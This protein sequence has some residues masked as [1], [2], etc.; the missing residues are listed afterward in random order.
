MEVIEPMSNNQ[1]ALYQN[2]IFGGLTELEVKTIHETIAKDCNEQQFKLFMGV[3]KAADAN[4]L[5][6]E[7]HPS[8]FSGKL[9]W[10]FGI[11]FFVRKAKETPGYQG[12]DVQ[13]VHENDEF[14]MHQE[15]A[16]DGRYY[17]VIDEH[18]WTFPRGKVIGGY[19]IAYKEGLKPFT[20]VMEVAE[21]EHYQKSQIGMQKTMW[22]NNFNDMF[23]KHM[24]K[25]AL[26][27]AFGLKFPDDES[28]TNSGPMPSYE[29]TARKDITN[30]AS[31]SESEQPQS[32]SQTGLTQPAAEPELSDEAKIKRARADMKA[33][34]AKLGVSKDQYE[35]WFIRNNIKWKNP[36]GP[37][38]SELTAV[39]RKM[40]LMIAQK[41]A[42]DGDLLAG[43]LD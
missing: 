30:E 39:L 38:L 1:V 11:D 28:E 8:V 27:A 29:P 2:F 43:E 26:K 22:T 31:H 36:E 32:A 37:T 24:L 4:P 18:S 34:F 42:E 7:I 13:L 6:G 23:K 5:L 15:R 14:K 12:Y 20:V 40:D 33:K 3:A 10:Q 25:R 21:V 41:N 9:T 19:A 16:E 17:A 35:D